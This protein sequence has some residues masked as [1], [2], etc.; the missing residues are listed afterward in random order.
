MRCTCWRSTVPP[1]IPVIYIDCTVRG[2]QVDHHFL[3]QVNSSTHNVGGT[4]VPL[5]LYS[6][7]TVEGSQIQT[8]HS[9]LSIN[10]A[11]NI[12]LIFDTTHENLWPTLL[13]YCGNFMSF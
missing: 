6:V 13:Q 1:N 4:A 12:G 11:L 10:Q 9:E 2:S 3:P 8:V 5:A 7:C